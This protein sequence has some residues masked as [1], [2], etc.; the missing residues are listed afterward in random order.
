MK[1]DSIAEALRAI[2]TGNPIN[3]PDTESEPAGESFER[4]RSDLELISRIA[5]FHRARQ[6][7][8]TSSSSTQSLE[9]NNRDSTTGWGPFELLECVGHGSFGDVYRAWD[10]RLDREVA[11]K[12]LKQSEAPFAFDG[13]RA[14]QEGRLLARVRH[15]NV[16]TVYGADVIDGRFGI[17][18][19]F[20]KGRTLDTI[21][22]E[23]GPF[24]V[25]DAWAVAL[26][27]CGALNAVHR[28]GLIHRDLKAQNVMRDDEGRF[29]LMDFGTGQDSG[30]TVGGTIAGTPLYLAPEV[31]A[32]APATVRSDLYSFGVFL[33]YLLTGTY[34]VEASSLDAL[35]EAHAYGEPPRLR[36]RRPDVPK[37]LADVI[38]RSIAKDPRDRFADAVALEAALAPAVDSI[39]GRP[40]LRWSATGAV[41]LVIVTA[42]L[43]AWKR[44]VAPPDIDAVTT[45]SHEALQAYKLSNDLG[46]KG[47]WR[48]AVDAARRAVSLDPQFASG[49]LWLAWCLRRSGGP[50][51]EV[52]AAADHAVGNIATASL[53]EQYWIRGTASYLRGEFV[54]ALQ[55]YVGLLTI[56][57]DHF[58]GVENA[59]AAARE[60]RPSEIRRVARF[61]ARRADLHPGEFLAAEHAAEA[62]LESGDVGQADAYFARAISRLKPGVPRPD[63][64]VLFPVR[65]AYL[66]G[67]VRGAATKLTEAAGQLQASNGSLRI[68]LAIT[69]IG[70]DLTLG[71]CDEARRIAGI[72]E[73]RVE[74]PLRLASVAFWCGDPSFREQLVQVEKTDPRAAAL[75]IE[76]GM[77]PEVQHLIDIA[78]GAR[79]RFLLPTQEQ[80]VA[81][82]EGQLA[83]AHDDPL[84]AIRILGP[85]HPQL[86][87]PFYQ[88]RYSVLAKAALK[89]QDVPGALA[90]LRESV[91]YRSPLEWL[92]DLGWLDNAMTLAELSHRLGRPGETRTL[93]RQVSDVLAVA[94]PDFTPLVRLRRLH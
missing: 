21:V 64:V 63:P 35:R 27:I 8:A 5:A 88:E 60:W 59:L 26:A 2:V 47:Q 4:A 74:R 28:A 92:T 39:A 73:S 54:N 52:I 12:L 43:V 53:W 6:D 30:E 38:D 10:S 40:L 32:G 93:E 82:L 9:H 89:R 11:L 76:G 37:R 31:L 24:A 90:V 61:V 78:H 3:W 80:E 48:P 50:Q 65:R 17:S 83:L 15:P 22:A 79:R 13:S 84:E 44:P 85:L 51:D 34:P 41:T 77:L 58:W 69:L 45:Q 25:M 19:E 71:R 1:D 91:I 94:D 66:R 72:I 68:G 16:M 87:S 18:M 75:L 36:T 7:P 62:F 42:A 20:V 86:S 46:L 33:F 14:V 29:V 55:Q 70:Y 49:Q 57:P 56:V 23:H 81:V 67:D